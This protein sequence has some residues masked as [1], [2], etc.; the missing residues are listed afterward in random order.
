[1]NIYF[2]SIKCFINVTS[3]KNQFLL[4]VFFTSFETERIFSFLFYL[5]VED[6]A[7]HRQIKPSCMSVVRSWQVSGKK[8]HTLCNHRCCDGE[9]LLVQSAVLSD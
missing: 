1:M 5:L 9:C 6:R 8:W 4:L 2:T 3:A 7:I